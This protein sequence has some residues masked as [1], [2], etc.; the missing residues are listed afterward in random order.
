MTVL[1]RNCRRVD[2]HTSGDPR[3]TR[4]WRKCDCGVCYNAKRHYGVGGKSMN[5]GAR[6]S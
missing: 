3:E 6:L 2:Q 4:E 5:F 1:L